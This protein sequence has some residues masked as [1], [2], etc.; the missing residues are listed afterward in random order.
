[1]IDASVRSIVAGRVFWGLRPQGQP[2]PAIVLNVVSAQRQYQMNGP[3][4]LK[5]VRV[6][7]DCWSP[8]YDE[9]KR[10]SRFV[11]TSLGGV[12]FDSIQGSFVEA[13]QDRSEMD[14]GGAK[15]HC[16]SL[17]FRIWANE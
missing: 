16:T 11:N 7:I 2:L 6:Q 1:M 4:G 5:S 13:E 17:D 15:V 12:T 10:L 9:A 14:A 3:A 8:T